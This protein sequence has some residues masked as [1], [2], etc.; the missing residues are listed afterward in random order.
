MKNWQDALVDSDISFETAIAKLNEVGLRILLFVDEE[1]KLL[2]TLTDGDVRRAIL[3][4]V[5]L[6]SSVSEVMNAQPRTVEK[7]ETSVNTINLMESLGLLHMPVVDAEGRA[8]NVFDHEVINKKK[9]YDNPVFIMA[10][11]F[12]KRLYPL[13]EDCPKPML[14]VGGRPILEHIL[15]RLREHNF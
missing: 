8:V 14:Q 1:R 4:R 3:K 12:G 11:G 5:P 13:T 15:T 9:T 10:G 7:S 6:E 2:G